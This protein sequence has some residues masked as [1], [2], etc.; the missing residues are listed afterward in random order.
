MLARMEGSR[1]LAGK[2]IVITGG[3]AGIG[4]ATARALAA[5]GARLRLLCRSA[6]KTAPVIDEL[7]RLAGHDDMVFVPMDLMKLAS[8]R[9]AA[10]TLL[11]R[12]EPLHVLI[13]NAGLGGQR[14][15][16]VDGFELHFGV[17]HL[18]HFLLTQLLEQRLRSSAPSRIVILSSKAHYKVKHVDWDLV[19]GRTRHWTGFPEYSVSK[20]C[21]LLHARTL[22]E[23]LADTGVSVYAVHPGVIASQIWNRIPQ[24][25]RWLFTRRMKSIEEGARASILCAAA[26]ELA[27]TTGQYH[28]EDGAT[29]RGSA[30]SLDRDLA[31]DL[32][33]RS[34]AWVAAT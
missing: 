23:R 18:G 32:W 22:A 8:V 5:R 13:N 25:F 19:Q 31:Q 34:E 9:E 1:D 16:T 17:N 4:L 3:N 6:E 26:P 24:P 2:V 21:N 7:R 14:G 29:K 30:L 33:R 12:N 27:G 20:L 10:R 11:A 28:D 15:Q